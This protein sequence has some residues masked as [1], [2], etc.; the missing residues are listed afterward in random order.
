[1][2]AGASATAM[3]AIANCSSAP[4]SGC[5]CPPPPNVM[6]E[7]PCGF[8]VVTTTCTGTLSHQGTTGAT[9][10]GVTGNCNIDVTLGDET[11]HHV[12]VTFGSL[13]PG[14]LE[15]PNVHDRHVQKI[16]VVPISFADVRRCRRQRSA[17]GQHD[18]EDGL[19][20]RLD[21]D[22]LSDATATD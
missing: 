10:D 19:R 18:A 2:L 3:A 6:L 8:E 22:A 20:T 4:W 17:V 11:T 15:Q 1:M 9:V 16:P 5:C 13:A 12:A 21:N 7:S 14:E